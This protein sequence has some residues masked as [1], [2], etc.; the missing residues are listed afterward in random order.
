MKKPLLILKVAFGNR[1]LTG[2]KKR[3]V[4]TYVFI[5]CLTLIPWEFF[6]YKHLKVWIPLAT[7]SIAAF[8]DG[9]NF[10][11]HPVKEKIRLPS[12]VSNLSDKILALNPEEEG[13]MKGVVKILI[14]Q[15]L[16]SCKLFFVKAARSWYGVMDQNTRKE[17]IKIILFFLYMSPA[18]IILLCK[19][20]NDNIKIFNMLFITITIYFWIMTIYAVS[21]ARYML[22]VFFLA[23][24]YYPVLYEKI[25]QK[26]HLLKF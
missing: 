2:L 15:P 1:L 21:M 26:K 23:I 13:Y 8:Q 11:H 9:I 19:K 5:I 18:F 25:V 20:N 16:P 12:D 24:V 7:S 6:N 4:L 3:W 14:S 22:P 17:Q 10:N